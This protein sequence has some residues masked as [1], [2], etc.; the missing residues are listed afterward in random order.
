[1]K[2]KKALIKGSTKDRAAIRLFKS[3][4]Y[5]VKIHGGNV[6][7]T[8][9]VHIIRWPGERELNW[10]LGVKCTGLPPVKDE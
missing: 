5:Y 6:M 3:V 2:P 4:A 7:V 1:M 9:G 10:T 8:G